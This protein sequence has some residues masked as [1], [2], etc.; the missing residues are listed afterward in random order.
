VRDQGLETYA[1]GRVSLEDIYL[2]LMGRGL[3]EQDSS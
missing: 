1:V 2:R 3:S